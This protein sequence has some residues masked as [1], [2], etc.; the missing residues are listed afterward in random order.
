ME[1]RAERWN[2]FIF[3]MLFGKGAVR[4]HSVHITVLL[5]FIQY[6]NYVLLT[7]EKPDKLRNY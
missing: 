6:L 5:N 4:N 1:H 2:I 7:N 3:V